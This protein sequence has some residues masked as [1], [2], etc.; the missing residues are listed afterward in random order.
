MYQATE[1]K[2][3]LT[4]KKM[5]KELKNKCRTLLALQVPTAPTVDDTQK[6]SPA[7]VVSGAETE[8]TLYTEGTQNSGRDSRYE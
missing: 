2:S 7:P 5:K 1:R 4:F 6:G 3:E 8:M